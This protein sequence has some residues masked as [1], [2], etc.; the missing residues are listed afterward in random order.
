MALNLEPLDCVIANCLCSVPF[1]LY[2]K[3]EGGRMGSS[4]MNDYNSI[5]YVNKQVHPLAEIGTQ[6]LISPPLTDPSSS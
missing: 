5:Q 2:S 6:S 4:R 3:R 1:V